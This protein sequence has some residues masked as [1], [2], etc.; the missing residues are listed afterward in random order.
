M[1]ADEAEYTAFI[2]AA[3]NATNLPEGAETLPVP[4]RR[5][6]NFIEAQDGF[7]VYLPYLMTS[8]MAIDHMKNSVDQMTDVCT[9][10]ESIAKDICPDVRGNTAQ[11]SSEI[12]GTS[13]F[14]S[15]LQ[16]PGLATNASAQKA[17]PQP[18][19]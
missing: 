14:M 16:F 2:R 4:L 18:Q 9:R 15:G 6:K 12:D 13:V 7:F 19:L 11:P 5:V 17:T 1:F 10:L 3:S 8:A